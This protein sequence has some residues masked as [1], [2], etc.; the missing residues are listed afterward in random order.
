MHMDCQKTAYLRGEAYATAYSDCEGLLWLCQK[1]TRSRAET[2][3]T[4]KIGGC[5]GGALV[6][7]KASNTHVNNRWACFSR[8]QHTGEGKTLQGPT[9]VAGGAIYASLS[10]HVV[11]ALK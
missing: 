7:D 11:S 1:V 3:E 6:F 8:T 9:P 4:N 2:N 5:E 10:L